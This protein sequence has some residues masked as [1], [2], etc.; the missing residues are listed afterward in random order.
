MSI[1]NIAGLFTAWLFILMGMGFGQL[2][3]F[4][5]IPSL[6][7]VIIGSIAATVVAYPLESIKTLP[8]LIKQAFSSSK[9]APKES[10][11]TLVDFSD[12]ARREGI[13]ALEDKAQKLDDEFLKKGIGL[14]VDGTE[15]EII[16][17]I[18]KTEITFIEDRHKRGAQMFE[19]MAT[20]APA[21]GMIGTLVGLIL[22]LGSMDDVST[23]GPN[24]AVALITTLY[25]SLMA[26][27]FC[28]PV[29]NILSEKSGQE[30]MVKNLM[31]EG[32][33]ALQ[34]GDN[35]RIVKQRLAAFLNPVARAEIMEED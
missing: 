25:G 20:I 29:A 12:Q 21:M 23:I 33:M 31:L 9:V 17:D 26:N 18:L 13:L 5:D 19:F 30:I 32:I 6:Q 34:T 15:P 28:T 7:I 24:M 27:A 11:T 8:A 10:I 16:R 35:P 1:S 3:T 14:A 22:M 2:G 4:I